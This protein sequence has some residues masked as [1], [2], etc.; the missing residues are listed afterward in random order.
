MVSRDGIVVTA[1]GAGLFLVAGGS[2]GGQSRDTGGDACCS[3]G[4][5]SS[6]KASGSC[7]GSIVTGRGGGFETGVGGGHGRDA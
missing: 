3:D 6:L 7:C 4:D 5:R 1:F 2:A